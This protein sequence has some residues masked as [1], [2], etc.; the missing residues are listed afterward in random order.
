MNIMMMLMVIGTLFAIKP[1]IQRVCNV[2]RALLFRMLPPHATAHL[3]LSR[4]SCLYGDDDKPTELLLFDVDDVPVDATAYRIEYV[5]GKARYD[6]FSSRLFWPIQ[7]TGNRVHVVRATLKCYGR[8]TDVTARIRRWA[9]IHGDFHAHEDN[10]AQVWIMFPHLRN[11][12]TE[13]HLEL[14]SLRWTYPYRFCHAS[15]VLGMHDELRHMRQ[16]I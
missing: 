5:S 9:G 7:K 10:C 13:L 6:A 8:E 16:Y 11:T 12:N 14:M 2:L 4:V 15:V 1:L 3:T